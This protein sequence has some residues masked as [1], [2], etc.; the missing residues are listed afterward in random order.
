MALWSDN[1]SVKCLQNSEGGFSLWTFI[2]FVVC[3]TW[4]CLENVGHS[5]GPCA[6]AS[7]SNLRNFESFMN[8]FEQITRCCGRIMR[9]ETFI[10]SE[11]FYFEL[12]RR[13]KVITDNTMWALSSNIKDVTDISE[14]LL[15]LIHCCIS[16]IPKLVLPWNP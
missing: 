6:I 3:I 5:F 15:L 1:L 14:I 4:K 7:N 9:F 16:V 11:T 12:S 10:I 2:D 13:L 8:A